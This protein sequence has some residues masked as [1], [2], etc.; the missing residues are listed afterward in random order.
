M[1]SRKKKNPA[2]DFPSAFADDGTARAVGRES[3]ASGDVQP[4]LSVDRRRNLGRNFLTL[5]FV[6]SA[7]LTIGNHVNAAFEDESRAEAARYIERA[8][9]LVIDETEHEAPIEITEKQRATEATAGIAVSLMNILDDPRNTTTRSTGGGVTNKDVGVMYAGSPETFANVQNNK[10]Y[11]GAAQGYDANTGE[12][13]PADFYTISESEREKLKIKEVYASVSCS[14]HIEEGNSL[15]DYTGVIDTAAVRLALSDTEHLSLEECSGKFPNFV[16]GALGQDTFL[17]Q[18][19]VALQPDGT[20]KSAMNKNA[21][22]SDG[23]FKSENEMQLSES[24]DVLRIPA[25]MIEQFKRDMDQ[26][27]SGA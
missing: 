4:R 13:L 22:I 26:V 10:L 17:E 23:P 8:N 9:T 16:R 12:H 25:A 7:G 15:A 19:N 20:L 3:S 11:I 5:F 18:F 6:T 27:D 1:F 2:N 21:R 14:F 24:A